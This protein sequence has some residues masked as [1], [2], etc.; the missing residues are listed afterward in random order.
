[1]FANRRIH[2]ERGGDEREGFIVKVRRHAG[3]GSLSKIQGAGQVFYLIGG[4]SV[5]FCPTSRL[6]LAL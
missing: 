6:D 1:M 3:Q 5:D 2:L 4:K